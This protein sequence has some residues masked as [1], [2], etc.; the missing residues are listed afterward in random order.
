MSGADSAPTPQDEQRTPES[1]R[2]LSRSRPTLE[3]LIRRAAKL[4]C[5]RCGEGALFCG[6][7]TMPERCDQCQLKYER[8]P[9][10]FLGAS[11]INYALTAVILTISY[12]LLH[13]GFHLSNRQLT[14][15]LVGFCILFPLAT[16]R[17]ARAFWLALDSHFD[18]SVLEE[19]G[20]PF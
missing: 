5:P 6:W 7:F 19:D 14:P 4:R 11:Y 1:V 17:H 12:M 20:H 13:F 18:K 16:F 2:E 8:A 15:V 10:Y 9:G 3:T